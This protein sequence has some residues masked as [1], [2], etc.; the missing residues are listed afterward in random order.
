[1][2]YRLLLVLLLLTMSTFS[3]DSVNVSSGNNKD[4]KG[5]KFGLYIGSLFANQYTANM[6]S[7]YG[8]DVDGNINSW[9][10]SWMNQKINVQYG[11]NGNSALTDQIAQALKV[12]PQTWPFSQLDMPI[13][14]HYTPAFS[15]G[16]CGNYSV[17]K[18]N[19]ILL[20]VNASKLNA[21]GNFT[22]ETLQTSSGSSTQMNNNNTQTFGIIGGEQRL[23]MQLGYQHLFGDGDKFN[24]FLEGGLTAT[25]AQFSKNSILINSLAIDL[26][27]YN[28][29]VYF[30]TAVPVKRPVGI[31]FGAFTGMGIN[32]NFNPKTVIQLV[33]NPTFEKINI[34][35]SPTIKLQNSIGL[36]LFYDMF[37]SSK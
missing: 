27:Q 35:Q 36:R 5:F 3:Q 37:H 16:L 25:L 17:D 30:P 22:I 8:F 32:V 28:N 1:M 4:S 19:A 29:S 26:V 2:K 12:D 13:N 31:G 33:Y 24:F 21:S 11:G 14:M 23:V 7:G 34:G 15:V 6:Y 20:N 10:N 18:R 9:D